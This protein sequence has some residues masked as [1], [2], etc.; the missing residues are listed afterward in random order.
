MVTTISEFSYGSTPLSLITTPLLDYKLRSYEKLLSIKSERGPY[1]LFDYFIAMVDDQCPDLINNYYDLIKNLHPVAGIRN[2]MK[3]LQ[4]KLSQMKTTYTALLF[5]I[6]SLPNPPVSKF[7]DKFSL[8]ESELEIV[9]STFER[10]C[11]GFRSLC[12][13]Y[14]EPSSVDVNRFFGTFRAFVA[15]IENSQQF[16]RLH[17]KESNIA[18]GNITFAAVLYKAFDMKSNNSTSTI[19][20]STTLE[21]ATID[22][23]FEFVS[24]LDPERGLKQKSTAH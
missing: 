24:S 4:D 20:T 17:K 7:S 16:H 1:S 3:D 8:T 22:N 18:N 9:Q 19:A 5:S 12:A 23:F 15:A 11:G 14:G 2:S 10:T 6:K 13:Q 21:D